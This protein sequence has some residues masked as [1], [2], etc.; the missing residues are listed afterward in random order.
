[1]VTI[2]DLV[3]EIVG[4]I[5]DEHEK[6]RRQQVPRSQAARAH[7]KNT[8]RTGRRTLML[9]AMV[10]G[11]VAAG[12]G[13]YL[14]AAESATASESASESGAATPRKEDAP[15]PPRG[16]GASPVATKS[17]YGVSV[18]VSREDLS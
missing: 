2:E 9:V 17:L 13:I 6:P 5:A 3:E 16:S 7:L 8:R 14:W 1:M 10:A 11:I 12:W 18:S 4:E 15:H